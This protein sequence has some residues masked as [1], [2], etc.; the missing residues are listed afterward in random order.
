VL[1]FLCE[2]GFIT[3]RSGLAETRILISALFSARQQGLASRCKAPHSTLR[4]PP[5]PPPLAV[6]STSVLQNATFSRPIA[7]PCTALQR[8]TWMAIQTVYYRQKIAGT[9]WRYRPLTVGRR[10]EAAK[11]GPYFIRVRNGPGRYQWLKYDTEQAAA[12]AAKTA[13]LLDKRKS[14]A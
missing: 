4:I 6:L 7:G 5:S 13:R 3:A 14:S 2:L 9:G 8:G 1:H 10:L 11:N 12:K